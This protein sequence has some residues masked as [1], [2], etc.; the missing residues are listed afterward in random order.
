MRRL[1]HS[2]A[3][4]LVLTL[5]VPAVEGLTPVASPLV[6]AAEAQT[7]SGSNTGGTAAKPGR[8]LGK[9][10]GGIAGGILLSI[11]AIMGIAALVKRDV[12]QALG[13]FVIVFIVGGLIWGQGSIQKMV[14]AVFKQLS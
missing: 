13:L 7:G 9:I 2:L 8:E 6:A 11:A 14:V 5:A 12:G 3:V 1:A 10:I 4:A